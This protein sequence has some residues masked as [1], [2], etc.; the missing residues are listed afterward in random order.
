M[1]K[2]VTVSIDFLIDICPQKY[3]PCLCTAPLLFVE[4]CVFA[5]LPFVLLGWLYWRVGGWLQPGRPAGG[6]SIQGQC[7][8]GRMLTADFLPPS[9]PSPPIPPS[10]YS[11]PTA[12]LQHSAT[13]VAQ[14]IY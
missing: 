5:F 10:F 7:L 12:T 4:F 2:L 3:C 13:S 11:Y 14:G 8:S 6:S 9:L 1:K